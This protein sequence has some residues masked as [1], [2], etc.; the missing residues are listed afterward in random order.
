MRCVIFYSELIFSGGF[1]SCG[2]PRC[3]GLGNIS[4]EK[5]SLF[6]TGVSKWVTILDNFL[7]KF[8]A[9]GSCQMLMVYI[10][11]LNQ[12]QASSLH[13]SWRLTPTPHLIPWAIGES[14][15]A[16]LY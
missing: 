7:C 5:V 3:P 1:F 15:C 16:S 8:L 10:W 2:S 6:P 4:T 13:F 14:L 9:G 12:G 11:T